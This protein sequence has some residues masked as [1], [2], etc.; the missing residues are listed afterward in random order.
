MGKRQDWQKIKEEKTVNNDTGEVIIERTITEGSYRQTRDEPAFVKLYL[1]T[2]LLNK[3]ISI[4][5]NPVLNELLKLMPYASSP[6]NYFALNKS[7]KI[8]IAEKTN[9]SLQT[10][11]N[12]IT[13]FVQQKILLRIDRGLYQMNPLFFGKGDWIDIKKIRTSIDF[14]KHG[15]IF[16][17]VEIEK[18]EN[19]EAIQQNT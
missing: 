18:E 13:E 15:I 5:R 8:I 14:S 7:I 19:T 17:Q 16:S 12:A 4:N 2:V 3:N 10:I 9:L 1:D 11:N 6:V